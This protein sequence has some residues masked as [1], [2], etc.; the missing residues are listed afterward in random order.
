MSEV[1]RLSERNKAIQEML[2]SGDRIKDFYRFA[3][4]NPHIDL[5]DACQIVIQKPNA[6]VCFGFD[7]WHAMGRRISKGRKGIPYFDRDGNKSFV[8]DANDTYGETRY[9]RHVLPMKCLLEGLDELN[10]TELATSNRRDYQKILSGVALYLQ[11]N[12]GFTDDEM[13]NRLLAE[14]IAFSLYNQTSYPK[15]NGIR[16]IGYP[17]G[18]TENAQLF[19]QV[20]EQAVSLQEEIEDAYIR[21]KERVE[22]IDD[23]E[24]EVITD[25][26]IIHEDKNIVK[27]NSAAYSQYKDYDVLC[28]GEIGNENVY[29]GKKENYDNMGNYDN[30]DNSL[31]LVSHN[32][33]MFRLLQGPSY[34]LSQSEMENR[35]MFSEE[36]YKE[37]NDLC[38]RFDGELE[39]VKTTTFSVDIEKNTSGYPFRYPYYKGNAMYQRYMATQGQYPDAFVVMRLG[40]FYEVM[41]HKAKEAAD[42]LDITLT[43][44]DCGLDERV[45]MC[46]FPYHV[47]Q[48][49]L[50]KLLEHSG[51]VA[52]EPDK[53]PMY[54]LSRQESREFNEENYRDNQ[55]E[56]EEQEDIDEAEEEFDD[57]EDLEDLDDLEEVI[58]EKPVK[59][60]KPEKG[61]KD[62]KRKEKPQMSLFDFMESEE[63]AEEKKREDLIKLSLKRGSSV[64]DGK[65]RICDKYH[66]NPTKTEF[67]N[68]LKDEYGIGGWSGPDMDSQMHDSKGVTIG[69]ADKSLVV[70]LKWN[71]VAEYVADLIDDN[72]YFTEK[73]K[74]E[75]E[76]VLR[77]RE[78][79][80][81]AKDNQDLT[82]IIARQI[83]EYGTE[84]AYDGKFSRHPHCLWEC[85]KFIDEHILEINKS[86]F[87]HK[88]VFDVG[89]ENE[90][91][92][93]GLNT[94]FYYDSC[95]AWQRRVERVRSNTEKVQDFA[96]DFILSC[97]GMYQEEDEDIEAD[98]IRWEIYPEDEGEENYLFLKDNR[99]EL[100]DYLKA[101]DGVKKASFSMN[102]VEIIFER[103]YI[104]AL[105]A[106]ITPQP[107]PVRK[108]AQSIVDN[109]VENG[110]KTTT[111][112]NWSVDFE[113]FG[114]DE[115]FIK[116]Y[117]P[118]VRFLFE[119][120][121]AVKDV[122]ITN[123]GIEANFNLQFCPKAELYEDRVV[124]E[125]KSL[126]RFKELSTESKELLDS[127]A[128]RYMDEPTYSMWGEVQSCRTIANGIYEVS[129]AGHGGV[130]ID[131][132]LAKEILSPEAVKVGVL[133][134]GYYCF[135]EDCDACVPL[136][137]LYD[138]GVLTSEHEYFT[139]FSVSSERAEATNKRVPF[140]NANEEEKTAFFDWWNNALDRSLQEWNKEYWE[141][142]EQAESHNEKPTAQR[143]LDA[144]EDE[145][146]DKLIE[147]G[148]LKPIEN[149]KKPDNTNLEE[150]GFNQAEFG[151]AKQRYKN[152]VE[153]IKLVKKLY[154]EDRE[155]TD[156]EK[157][158]LAKYV[159]WGGI[160][161]AFDE[162]N[163]KWQDEF[164]ELKDILTPTEYETAKG[165][166]L[167]AHFTS[168]EV[169]SGMYEALKE[170]GVKGGNRIL[171]PALGTGNFFGFM[172]KEIADGARLYGVEL[173]E[174]TG[175]I[176]TKLYPNANIQIK[177]FEQTTFADNQF[178]LMVSNVPFGNYS[179]YDSEYARQSFQIHD[180]FIAKGIDKLK[181]DGIMAVI[182]SK[183]TLDKQ[184]PTVRK[185]I[186]DRAELIGAIRLP[187]TAFKQTAGT[188]V[189][190]DILFF[191]KRYEKINAT[192]ENT[193]WLSVG[194]NEQGFQLNNYYIN[195][196]EMLCGT[197]AEEMGLYG[198][199]D[200]TLKPDDRELGKAISDAVSHLPKDFYINP[201]YDKEEQ[202]EK[203]EVDYNIR[204]LCYKAEKGKLYMRVG[205]EMIE[206]TIPSTPKDAYERITGM[207]RLRDNIRHLLDI[208]LEGCPDE[209]LQREQAVLNRNYDAFVKRYGF[210]NSST[211]N[212]LFRE[213]ADSALLFSAENI[214]EDKKSATKADIFSKRTIRPYTV[215]TQTDDCFEALQISRN[216]KGYVDIA[217]IEELTKKDYD[218]VLD[219]LGNA[220]FRNP[221]QVDP[222]DKYSGF[223]TQEEYLSGEV[224]RKLQQARHFVSTGSTEF[225]RNVKALEEVQPIPLKA[226]EISVKLGA[227]W[228][229]K[230]IYKQCLCEMLNLPRWACDGVDFFYNRHDGSW[231]I[232]KE[233]YARQ[234]RYMEV[235]RVY[236]TERANAFRLFEDC[237]NQKA[238]QIYDMVEDSDG[239]T[240]RV[241]NQAETIAARE[242][243]NKIQE[244]FKSWIYA[245]PER[246]DHLEEKYNS[247]FNKTRVPTYDGSHL[248]FPE[249]NPAIELRP[250]QKNAVHR[251]T[252]TGQNTLLHHVVGSG[253]TMTMIASGMKLKQ[254]GL[255]TK[256]MYVVPNHLVQQWADEFRKTY[257]NANVLITQ[258]DDLDKDKRQRFVSKV[259]MGDWDGIIIA[260]ST[261]AKI[262]ISPE[263]QIKKLREEIQGIEESITSQWVESNQPRG[264][265][266]NLERIKKSREAQLKKLMDDTKKDDILIFEKLGVDYLFVD[267]SDA[268][269]NLFLYTKMNNVAGIST[270]ASARAS[271]M[272]MK[273]E[274]I[275]E[276]HGGDKGVVFATGTPISN[277]M[278]EMYTLQ[279]YL[280]KQTLEDMG[281]NYFDAWAADFGETIT[282]LEL[283]PSG[284]GYRAKTRFAKFT[285]LP[286]LLTMYRSFAD[287]Q[288]S[289]MVKL[290]VPTAERKV[291]T[292]KPSDAVIELTKEIADRAERIYGGGVDPHEDN[293]L[294]VTSDGK[295]IA[296]DPRC[297]DPLMGDEEMSKINACVE[298]VVEYY[299]ES[300]NIK[301][302]QLIFCDLST[303]K[304]AFDDY[305]YGR[306]FDAYNDIKHKLVEEG[307][308]AEEIAFIHDANSDLQKQALFNKVNEGTVRIL[309][310]STEKCGAGTNV[311]KRL[312]ALHHLD[313][314]Y[315]PRDLIQRDGRGIRQGN[316]NDTVKI[317]TYV[318]ERTFDSYS[319]QILENKQRFISQIERGDLTVRE[320]EDI[321]EAT[322]SYAE[323][324]AL[325][326]ANPKIKRK[327][328]LDNELQ[329]LRILEGRYTK[330][331]FE[332]QDEI[333]KTLPEQIQRQKLYL[334]R[335]R[336]DKEMAQ[337]NF[338]PDSFSI[339]VG[340]KI[341]TD[342]KEGAQA[343]Q[344]AIAVGK[345][346]V[347][348]A[349]YC[350]F[351]I[352]LDPIVMLT[353]ERTLTVAG[354]GQY[355]SSVMQTGHWTMTHLENLMQEFDKRE[356][357][358]ITKLES[359][360]NELRTAQEQVKI[361][362]EHSEKIAEITR[363]LTEINAE[364]DL[365][366]KEEVV[367]DDSDGEGDDAFMGLPEQR[368]DIPVR[369]KSR[370]R[371]SKSVEKLYR[372]EQAKAPESFVFICDK[373]KYCVVG[374]KADEVAEMTGLE[375]Q[376]GML[377]GKDSKWLS[378]PEEEFATVA[379]E[380]TDRKIT[381]KIVMMNKKQEEETFI[382]KTDLMEQM[383]VDLYPDYRID[384]DDMNIYGYEWNGMLPMGKSRAKTYF[385]MGLPIYFLNDNDTETAMQSLDDIDNHVGLFGIEKDVWHTF[386]THND[387]YPYIVARSEVSNAFSKCIHEEMTE[388]D[389]QFADVLSDENFPEKEALKKY[390]DKNGLGNIQKAKAFVPQLIEEYSSRF[391]GVPLGAYGWNIYDVKDTI[392]DKIESPE[393]R[394]TAMSYIDDMKLK[395]HVD[396]WLESV[397]W[398]NGRTEYFS[399]EEVDKIIPELKE[400]AHHSWFDVGVEEEDYDKWYEEFAKERLRPELES[401]YARFTYADKTFIPYRVFTEEEKAEDMPEFSKRLAHDHDLGIADLSYFYSIYPYS[402]DDFYEAARQSKCDI[403]LC[404]ENGKL[405]V[406]GQNELFMF[407]G[408]KSMYEDKTITDN[409]KTE[410]DNTFEISNGFG[411][412]AN[413][414]ATVELYTVKDP[415]FGEEMSGLAIQLWE[416]SKIDGREVREP[417]ALIT[418][419]F[420]ESIGIKNTAYIDLNNC[421]FATDL[422][423]KGY[424]KDMGF[425][426]ESG[427]ATYPLWQFDE[428][429]LKKNG[430]ENYK[431]Y[432][433]EWDAYMEKMSID[434]ELDDMSVEEAEELL[435]VK[436]VDYKEEV[437]KSIIDEFDKFKED[438]ISKGAE[439]V[440]NNSHRI[441]VYD[442]M[443]EVL[444]ADY[445]VSDE[446]YKTLYEDRG[447]ILS[448][449]AN[450]STGY[451][452]DIDNY[453]DLAHIIRE[454]CK[455]IE[456]ERN[457]EEQA[458]Y[459]GTNRTDTAF[460][461]FKDNIRAD[462][463][464][465]LSKEADEYVVVAPGTDLTESE[466]AEHNITFIEL[467][468]DIQEEDL[469][470]NILLNVEG[471]YNRM[472]PVNAQQI[473]MCCKYDIQAAIR[474]NFNGTHLNEGFENDLIKQYGFERL[475]YVLANTVQDS[476]HDGRYSPQTKEWAR[477]ITIDESDGVKKMMLIQEHPAVL[478]GFINRIRRKEKEQTEV[479]E[480]MPVNQETQ[481]KRNWL[482]AK[483]PYE[484][485]IQTREKH[486]F[487]RMP[488][489]GDYSGYTYNLFNNRIKNSTR[490][491]DIQ[492][493][494]REQCL[495]LVVAEDEEILLRKDDEE[496]VLGGK[497]FI[498]AVDNTF[499]EDYER[500]R[501]G[502]EW[503]NIS[504]PRDAMRGIYDQST[505]FSMPTNGEYNGYSYYVP[506]VFVDEDTKTDEGRIKIA[507]PDDFEVNVRNRETK[508]KKVM[509]PKEFAELVD[510][511]NKEDYAL[512][513]N[514]EQKT[515]P[516]VA[517]KVE[518]QVEDEKKDWHY[519]SVSKEARLGQYEKAS[520]FKMPN[521]EYGSY[522]YYIP[523]SFLK[524]NE[525][526]GTIRVGL[527]DDM[528]VTIKDKAN[529]DEITLSAEEYVKAVKGKTAED[530]K[531]DPDTFHAPQREG[532]FNEQAENTLRK[533]VPEEM[534]ERPNWIA[535]R[536]RYNEERG[537][538]DKYL[539]NPH[540]GKFAESDNP[541]TW[542]SF[543]DACKFARE[544][545]CDAVAYA[546]DGKGGIA[547]IDLDSCVDEKGNYSPF[548]QEV[549][550]TC[551]KTYIETSLSGKGLHIFGTTDGMD[552][553]T[554]SKDGEM[555]F[556]Q[557]SHFISM[558]GDGAG[559]QRLESFDKPDMKS[560]IERKCEKRTAWNGVGAGIEGLSNM[561]DRDVTE[562]AMKSADGETFKKLYNGQDIM[563]DHSRSDMAL[564]SRLA[565]WCNGDKEQML[566]V[567]ATSG[568]Y[569]PNKSPD[570]Y[571]GTAIKCIQGNTNR[572]TPSQ[573]KPI[574]PTGNSGG[575]GKK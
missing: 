387:T 315:R 69:S 26:P 113:E 377:N 66:Q 376:T 64:E 15:E 5:H 67:A 366:K 423:N 183:G 72:E 546:L 312:C 23:T 528:K 93:W 100:I 459:L 405:Y 278:A 323:I 543:D 493:D 276:L 393:L 338:N 557:K 445:Y 28:N 436:P 293:M 119:N 196:P 413:V 191:R 518:A 449:L 107:T 157:K 45:P 531:I 2:T 42:I 1:N 307:I 178:D 108:Q 450:E 141:A 92:Y 426:K 121:A 368:E 553:R 131:E 503:T 274:Y 530:Y 532:K 523:N 280:Q 248:K 128:K 219:E 296:L 79:R 53:E 412:T 138:K 35:G 441:R 239:R 517:T 337:A 143:D 177:G 270:A 264:A 505:L 291:V 416:T 194:T 305:E 36:D 539:I 222:E 460:Y 335:V 37:Y 50:G 220:V 289:D 389:G 378:I 513:R 386:I 455:D 188:E 168:K 317:N 382:D 467:G 208:Q 158:V 247:I 112:G 290:D 182:T 562:K 75:Y 470:G 354:A 500:Q 476:M 373:D 136:R 439:E 564:M 573:P 342:R 565:F 362:F 154:A 349:E 340:G 86:L 32:T 212:R 545:G 507:L 483:V 80:A 563:N 403:F 485:V 452:L 365:N 94:E 448:I 195:H 164:K 506:N 391:E 300:Q 431:K 367:I 572:Y 95:P 309:I 479:K 56:D 570:Y 262:G 345:T 326:S 480:E 187:N 40:D 304:K 201:V 150:I 360:E 350:G 463:L 541:E 117:L 47:S 453:N 144:E 98:E 381:V 213:D 331:L 17:Y 3:A 217:Y 210:L 65:F 438:L 258:K 297:Y 306:D 242:K 250:H 272:Q 310:G 429:F 192:S 223:Q 16:L 120:N 538:Y 78:E 498:Q 249:M 320:A 356:E 189:T 60:K 260:Q 116:D 434:N 169:I 287:V 256:P 180:Y 477:S 375:V 428:E 370:T 43:G 422:L 359:L 205:D 268:Y 346:D 390:V 552:V 490:I 193:E 96:D 236:G 175:K 435:D 398:L 228:V 31:I 374:D 216:E 137:E 447:S 329:Q 88:E 134:G 473:N 243:Q 415:I 556:Y 355:Q 19:C 129:T 146:W 271:D 457:G 286:E 277:S 501:E 39:Q 44:R 267:E 301:G 432:S 353:A 70:N 209:I 251:I 149:D 492:S 454:Y 371:I 155:P 172:P 336:K 311:Q 240:K 316:M 322:L 571:E 4:Q 525:E 469:I 400:Q 176:A 487:M 12:E 549:L 521:G 407:L 430:G 52:L 123:K 369:V 81:G 468:K 24:E 214:S 352:S 421:P 478:D 519:V 385:D 162:N 165:S 567:F 395:D 85:G 404:E 420:G 21:R 202:A 224:V 575:N 536:T 524:D 207:I 285:N 547:C 82:R 318:R 160:P 68:F 259:A 424:A 77:F 499:T 13:K 548:A 325:T 458:V 51:V 55:V 102:M 529:N 437:R 288:T 62:R 126:N 218:T 84:N 509:T 526:K 380:L 537:R 534:R 203:I 313:A 475:N 281:I 472:F 38:E 76:Q 90:S 406:P 10:G 252:S 234:S 145:D 7:E 332:L 273:I 569:R 489:N 238:T 540:T 25:E 535:V 198:I 14:G 471:V 504:V 397:E 190:S 414:E 566:R 568:L 411:G 497:D 319:Y 221:V 334:E 115:Q 488:L 308:P 71:E 227:S 560:L 156:S 171:E 49:Y 30:T 559:Y 110:R 292:I 83:V 229:D 133:D 514:L 91:F 41:G 466:L 204:P 29:L 361:P 151:G 461:L 106:G 199:K 253:K 294:K 215:A 181:P 443:Y 321:D 357:R 339:N 433:E 211:N 544:N 261:F 425:K 233:S 383:Q 99:E 73:E 474:D 396:I 159:G 456:K 226:S 324:K 282:S 265:V 153:A 327:M 89:G 542:T 197:L 491:T 200:L 330:S 105:R 20:R 58:E 230:D 139:H 511:T 103:G 574:K 283:A 142:H 522:L 237:M 462:N 442:N 515:E 561:S 343:L 61:I 516:K 344:D 481:E 279:T 140:I 496:V 394:K 551:G 185:Y 402:H 399:A 379:N 232:D 533:S 54:I 254:Y 179:V 97:A 161:Q 125:Q 351:K 101:N 328:E 314:P 418:K 9:I 388:F 11:Q 372:T 348:L 446:D 384:Q 512:K 482:T 464:H 363:E 303:P 451:E 124:E 257:P 298:Q 419:N 410:Q 527:P 246:R 554:F 417:Y 63:D 244:F 118:L 18:L 206:Q 299:N 550:N 6:S 167:N 263:R 59:E 74:A 269:K 130:I 486:S 502:A 87:E 284:Q 27:I 444:F 364:L 48:E 347:T 57:I 104:Q 186:A 166:V 440:F 135:E 520:L 295:K 127:Y 163:E 34:V 173:D 401:R 170:M 427:Y 245:D 510:K 358:A 109:F 33:K 132:Q 152:N 508:D 408:E 495:E 409:L 8:F 111:Q 114:K 22:V 465:D 494:S 174:I 341:Y 392:S 241:L 235:H 266:K 148:F 484:A 275:N 147:S 255:A 555:E 46:G 302:T 231:R 558:T 184:S 225:E 122:E 333:R